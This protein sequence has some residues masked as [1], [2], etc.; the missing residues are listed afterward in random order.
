M[1]QK[2]YSPP[3]PHIRLI[4][5]RE[6]HDA[7]DMHKHK[8]MS[9]HAFAHFRTIHTQLH[10]GNTASSPSPI[11]HTAQLCHCCTFSPLG[12]IHALSHRRGEKMNAL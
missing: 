4:D 5:T 2:S 6:M 3:P 7:R 12:G 9:E 10:T 11:R 1:K 8:R